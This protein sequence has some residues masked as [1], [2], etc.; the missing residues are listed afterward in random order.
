MPRR[1]ESRPRLVLALQDSA[2]AV[3]RERAFRRRGWEV[4]RASTGVEARRLAA[5]LLPDVVILD[6]DLA[7][8][9]GWLTCAKL[10]L[11][12]PQQ[13]VLLVGA[14]I[15]P[16]NERFSEFVGAA[17]LVSSSADLAALVPDP[18]E[19]CLRV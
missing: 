15:T 5:R 3:R 17:G 13:K 9:S 2:Q 8:E 18:R 4:H 10:R 19:R 1:N 7:D 6:T 12:R 11:E 14:D 16:S